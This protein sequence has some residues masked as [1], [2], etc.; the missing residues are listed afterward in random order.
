MISSHAP[1]VGLPRTY[2]M[3]AADALASAAA[4]YAIPLLVLVTTGSTAL[5]SLAFLLEWAPRLAAFAFAG[6]LADGLT[7]SVTP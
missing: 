7:L 2:L 5:T 1:T 4:T 3:R 6:F